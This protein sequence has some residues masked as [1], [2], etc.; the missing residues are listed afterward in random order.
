MADEGIERASSAAEARRQQELITQAA[1][2]LAGKLT[3]LN[4]SISKATEVRDDIVHLTRYGRTNRKFVKWL[5]IV[6][7]CL[8]LFATGL[9]FVINEQEKLTARLDS[10]LSIQR[11]Q[12]LC[13]L[14]KLF[15][16]SDTPA[17]REAAKA[18]GDNFD[19]RDFAFSVIRK[20]YSALRCDTF[21]DG[22]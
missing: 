19:D 4:E 3:Q 9:G 22:K 17:S 20:S 5:T 13:P 6:L 11:D 16:N 10:D 2:E 15:I 1:N 14:Y 7:T 21:I 8:A 18:R 12:A